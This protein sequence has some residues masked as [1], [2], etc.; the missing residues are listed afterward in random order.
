MKLIAPAVTSRFLKTVAAPLLA[1]CCFL[2]FVPNLTLADGLEVTISDPTQVAAPNGTVVFEGTITNDTGADLSAT[3]IFFDFLTF[4]PSLDI[5][6]LL[7]V[8]DDFSIP[9]GTTTAL[10][11]LF[12]IGLGPGNG[13]FPVTFVIQDVNGNVSDVGSVTVSTSS[14][15]APE[16]AEGILLAIGMSVLLGSAFLATKRSPA[17]TIS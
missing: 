17:Q 5:N 7:G 15:P 12:S 13:I 6:Q 11:D 16:P 4:D 2:L 8:E 1:A 14:V 9:N 3:D 10:V